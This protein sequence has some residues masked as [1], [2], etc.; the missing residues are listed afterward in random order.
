L[1]ISFLIASYL[2]C[3][4][5][6]IDL[7]IKFPI[8]AL[9]LTKFVLN[10][11]PETRRS[12][13]NSIYDLAAVIVHHGSGTSNGHYTAYANTNGGWMHF[14]DSSV[15]EVAE[16]VVANCKPYILFYIKRDGE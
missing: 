5:T 6:K 13:S 8:Q 4:R 16:Q 15:K 10:N 2:F 3:L 12:N 7:Q 14:N 9:D 1:R 11:G